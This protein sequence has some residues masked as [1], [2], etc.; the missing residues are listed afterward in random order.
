VISLQDVTYSY[1]DAIAPVL[2]HLTLEI[3]AGRFLLVIGDSGAG[4]STFLRCLNGLVPHF[5][6]GE[7]SGRV[8]AFGMDTMEVPPRQM[9]RTVGF[10]FQDPDA[11]FVAREVEEELAFGMENLNVPQLTMRKRIEEVLDQLKIA[12]L[13][14][15]PVDTLSGGE[16]QRVAIAA[17]LVA[18][19][20]AL[21][22]DE[23]T[24]QLDPQAAEEVLQALRGLND[25]LGITIVLAEHRLERVVQFVDRVL[26]L[27]GNGE[28]PTVGSAREVMA[29]V[30]LTP[31]LISLGKRLGWKP[32][33]LTIK[34]GMALTDSVSRPAGPE[35]TRDSQEPVSRGNVAVEVCDLR[36]AYDGREA[37]RG[38]NLSV[39]EGELVALMG[40]N[41]SGKTTLLKHMVGLLRP[42]SGRILMRGED[43]AG[44]AVDEIC[45]EVGLVPQ[46]PNALLFAD[47]VDEE[48]AFTLG[49]RPGK[50]QPEDML[51]D[52][53][54]K[55]KAG[56]YPRDLSEGERQRASIA[57]MLV[58]D[59]AVILLDEPTRGLD[60]RNKSLLARFLQRKRAEGKAVIM[61]THDV[62]LVATCADRVVLIGEGEVIIDGP[63]REVLSESAI[64]STQVNKLFRG[65]SW[66]TVED[67]VEGMGL[68]MDGEED[69]R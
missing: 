67:A 62:E 17:A 41:G 38:V 26:H 69:I 9:G 20:R 8:T 68:G 34:E 4:K 32:L 53:N 31:P 2:S 19:P 54:M 1:P 42:E 63:T 23:P 56:N 24:S 18:Q 22:L 13:R 46:N 7:F 40:R 57:A 36:F 61:A 29:E 39:R 27:P 52:L 55:D 50:V 12:H 5:H 10:V 35:T 3:P 16:K 30:P 21:V 48:L 43:I 6:G 11:Q 45:G 60:Y 58:S 37:L 15:R 47:T 28:E 49:N 33:P 44:K 25:D 66:L 64:F 59:P 14:H 65:T 51:R